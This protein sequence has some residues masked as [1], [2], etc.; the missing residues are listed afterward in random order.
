MYKRL[1]NIVLTG[2]VC[3]FLSGNLIYAAEIFK[4]AR[5]KFES[6]L[7]AESKRENMEVWDTDFNGDITLLTALENNST[8]KTDKT[9]YKVSF[10]DLKEIA[11]FPMVFIHGSGIPVFSSEEIKNMREY[12]QRGG[13]IYA[14]DCQLEP[15]EDYF[16]LEMK[17]LVEEKIFPGKKLEPLD[18]KHPIFD[19]FYHFP[20]GFPLIVG[21][22]HP[23]LGLPDEKGR[24]MMFLSSKDLHCGWHRHRQ[25]KIVQ[26]EALKGG[27]NIIIYALTN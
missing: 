15:K 27:I 13:L 20:L 19:C 23:F 18:Y 7:P 8:I 1:R 6:K 26:R 3:L 22:D 17:K 21:V 14:E 5:V 9:I 24:L 11:G 25:K 2:L 12:M 4:W 16:Y 10:K